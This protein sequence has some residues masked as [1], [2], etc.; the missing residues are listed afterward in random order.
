MLRS[1]S[2]LLLCTA[3]LASAPVSAG[4]LKSEASAVTDYVFRGLS[5]TDHGP[6]IRGTMSYEWDLGLRLG[7]SA[8]N[9]GA[10]DARGMEARIDMAYAHQINSIFGF[11]AKV[12][13]YHDPYSVLANTLLYTASLCL[14]PYLELSVAYSPKFFGTGTHSIYYSAESWIQIPG[15]EQVFAHPSVGYSTF[16][17]SAYAGNKNY[18]D[19]Q[20]A[21]HKRVGVHD[22]GVFALN[23]NR[24]LYDGKKVDK[25]AKDFG[26]GASYTVQLQ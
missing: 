17:D 10:E 9:T 21:V 19:Y 22:V 3:L 13:A 14:S 16:G 18:W 1:L 25:P 23:T 4:S 15:V 6:S 2:Q 24:Q 26:F 20:L 7:A 5:R 8:A 11:K 12:Q